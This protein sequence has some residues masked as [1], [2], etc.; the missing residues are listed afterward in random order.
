MPH[1]AKETASLDHH[2]ISIESYLKIPAVIYKD[3]QSRRNAKQTLS[4]HTQTISS[5]CVVFPISQKDCAIMKLA[6]FALTL[7]RATSFSR[8]VRRSGR[9][10]CYRLAIYPTP[11][12]PVT[13][14]DLDGAGSKYVYD[15]IL[16]PG[17]GGLMGELKALITK[18]TGV[19]TSIAAIGIV[20]RPL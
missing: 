19:H 16:P 8:A 2:K 15:H 20:V 18:T 4:N 13:I 14:F 7:C 10:S 5:F 1:H 12:Q 9:F 11:E 3:A 6:S 17:D